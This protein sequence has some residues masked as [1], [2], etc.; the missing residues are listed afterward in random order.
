MCFMVSSIEKSEERSLKKES[1]RVKFVLFLGNPKLD[2][3]QKALASGATAPDP[4]WGVQN[5]HKKTSS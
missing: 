4:V 1:T 3:A 2:N 5:T